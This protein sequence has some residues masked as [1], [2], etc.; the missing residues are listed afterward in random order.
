MYIYY[1]L[2]ALGPRYHK[3]LWWKK[4]MTSLQIV[5]VLLEYL[6]TTAVILNLLSF[7]ELL[8]VE[9]GAGL[10]KR[11]FGGPREGSAA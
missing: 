5:C 3:Y 10:Q 1:A 9:R 6:T 2:S 8:H 7:L 11:A 4:Y